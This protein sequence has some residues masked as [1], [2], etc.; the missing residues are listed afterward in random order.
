MIG[1]V[2]RVGYTT[3]LLHLCSWRSGGLPVEWRVVTVQSYLP[4]DLQGPKGVQ[5][6]KECAESLCTGW[7]AFSFTDQGGA[8]KLCLG[9]NSQPHSPRHLFVGLEG[10]RRAGPQTGAERLWEQQHKSARLSVHNPSLCKILSSRFVDNVTIR[11]CG[12][13]TGMNTVWYTNVG[14]PAG[15]T[16]VY[17]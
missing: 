17:R 2:N 8:D 5:C 14:T 6:R 7:A 15:C 4:P 16:V 1:E 10:K 13:M 11:R 3:G 12:G 9:H